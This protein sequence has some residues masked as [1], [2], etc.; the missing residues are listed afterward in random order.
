MFWPS[1]GRPQ[2]TVFKCWTTNDESLSKNAPCLDKPRCI[3]P[4]RYRQQTQWTALCFCQWRLWEVTKLQSGLHIDHPRHIIPKHCSQVAE[5]A[6][7]LRD[8]MDVGGAVGTAW[9]PLAQKIHPEF[10]WIWSY[11]GLRLK[12]VINIYIYILYIYNEFHTYIYI[13]FWDYLQSNGTS[14]WRINKMCR[15]DV[16]MAETYLSLLSPIVIGMGRWPPVSNIVQCER[17]SLFFSMKALKKVKIGLEN[18]AI[19]R[20]HCH[21]WESMHFAY[22]NV[23]QTPGPGFCSEFHQV[24]VV[25][26]D[27][28]L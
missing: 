9:C 25:Q 28:R 2:V 20:Y 22:V 14:L 23:P 10:S 12:H 19:C 26:W 17:T 27:N 15:Y 4:S 7:K 21:N 24:L 3:P 6:V 13:I 16:D 5:R 18:P 11:K 1:L 8:V